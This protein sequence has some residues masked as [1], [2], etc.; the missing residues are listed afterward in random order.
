M[1]PTWPLETL[2]TATFTEHEGKTTITIHW[3]AI[4]ATAEEQKTFDDSHE[5]MRVGYS[6]TF[7]Q[8]EAFLANT[9]REQKQ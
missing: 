5:G 1:S 8:L 3:A 7:D 2:A 4:N 6:G 9:M